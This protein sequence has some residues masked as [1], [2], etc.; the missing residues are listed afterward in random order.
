MISKSMVILLVAMAGCVFLFTFWSEVDGKQL[1]VSDRLKN[2]DS[3]SKK[4]K[5]MFQFLV[6]GV[7]KSGTT[8]LYGYLTTHP[9]ISMSIPKELHFFDNDGLDWKHPNYSL[10]EAK[11]RTGSHDRLR[12]EASPK[13]IC[14]PNAFQRIKEYNHQ[15]K[16]ILIFRDPVK[17]AW[18]HYNV[19]FNEGKR[20]ESFA[21]L[22]QENQS[23]LNNASLAG[24]NSSCNLVKRG[25]YGIQL[26][27][28]LSVFPR[29]QILLLL[30]ENMEKDP[31]GVLR[32]ISEFLEI[33]Y[34]PPVVAKLHRNYGDKKRIDKPKLI[35]NETDAKYLRSLY[36][37]DLKLFAKLSRLNIS[38]WF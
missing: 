2:A 21:S 26:Q 32:K 16:I 6:A 10:Y 15:M 23:E 33:S 1:V 30:L 17:R 27:Q 3:K 4:S 22:I 13:Y 37:E 38:H 35:M 14:W 7:M 8:T 20:N 28:L 31:D 9:N 12:G 18:S 36:K 19:L 25:F 11:K 34:P 29:N 24:P 5:N